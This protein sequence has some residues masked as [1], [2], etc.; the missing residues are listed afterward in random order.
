MKKG[1]Y[2]CMGSGGGSSGVNKK[3]HMHVAELNKHF[4]TELVW[5]PKRERGIFGKVWGLL[6]WVSNKYD[7]ERLFDQ[8]SSPDFLYIRYPFADKKMLVFLK[9][10]KETYA[11]CKIIIEIPTY[12]YDREYWY[13]IDFFFLLKDMHYRK[14]LKQYVDR[15][16]TYSLEMTIWDVPTI[17]TINGTDVHALK[18]IQPVERSGNEIH[19]IAVAML[20]KHHGFERMIEGIKRYYEGKDTDKLRRIV[21][22]IVGDGPEKG[23]YEKLV[24]NYALSDQVVFHGTLSG[25]K[26]D[27]VYNQADIAVISLGLYKINMDYVSTLK[28]GEYLAKGMPVIYACQEGALTENYSYCLKVPNDGSPLDIDKIICFYDQIYG[29]S[30]EKKIETIKSIRKLAEN[31]VGMDKVMQPVVQYI[32]DEPGKKEFKEG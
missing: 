23:K 29:G 13:S 28:A 7:Y 19:L 14:Q 2:I 25:E 6:F 30:F 22:H 24:R 12:P 15:F 11:Q 1:Y 31:I 9:R 32:K 20:Q 27:E 10:I 21:F 4:L 8:L 18:M 5:V 17:K 26:L 3:V 16:V